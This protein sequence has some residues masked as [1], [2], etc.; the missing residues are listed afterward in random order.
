M[1]RLDDE[2]YYTSKRE[3]FSMRGLSNAV[4]LMKGNPYETVMICNLTMQRGKTRKKSTE[5]RLQ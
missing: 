3:S 1:E 2:A 4:A 5:S